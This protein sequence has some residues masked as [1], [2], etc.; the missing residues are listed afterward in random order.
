MSVSIV[1][2]VGLDNNQSRPRA[3]GAVEQFN[4][5]L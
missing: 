2:R 1:D 5:D 3:P 4:K